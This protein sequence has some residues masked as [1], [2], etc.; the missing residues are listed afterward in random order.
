MLFERANVMSGCII[1][2]VTWSAA[3]SVTPSSAR[4]I[5]SL[6]LLGGVMVQE[7]C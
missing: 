6:S 1:S 5:V 3:P 4:L 2:D 7:T